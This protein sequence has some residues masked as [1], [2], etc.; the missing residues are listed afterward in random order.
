MTNEVSADVSIEARETL[1]NSYNDS[2]SL[3]ILVIIILIVRHSLVNGICKT[4]FT[5][6]KLCEKT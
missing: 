6:S 1:P 5:V 2:S 4:R 3:V